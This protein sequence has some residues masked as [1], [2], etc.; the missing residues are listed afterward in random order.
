MRWP[1]LMLAMGLAWAP[2]QAQN[3]RIRK[4]PYEGRFLVR[5]G[6]VYVLLE[7]FAQALG[8]QLA[9][10]GEGY[11]SGPPDTGPVSPGPAAGILQVGSRQLSLLLESG[12]VFVPAEAYSQALGL[13]T[14]RDA[15]GALTIDSQ[16]EQARA[17][18]RRPP[19]DPESYF[20]TQYP[21]RYNRWASAR[22]A[23]CGPACMSMVA[24]AYGVA[25]QGLLPGDRQALILW[26][27]QSMTLG[28]QDQGRGTTYHEI[29]RAATQMGLSSRLIR[30]FQELDEALAQGQLVVVAGDTSR[31]GWGGGDHF[32]LCVGRRGSDY[33][34]ND[35]GGFCRVA[36]TRLPADQMEKFFSQAIALFPER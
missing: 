13:K 4:Q 20:V 9:P 30:R 17:A 16:S 8:V 25:P 24:L 10:A 18:V 1:L 7:P 34:I 12:D 6:Q 14:G 2:A 11:W 28:S 22:N 19:D 23:N 29:E 36:G 5:H 33:L 26:C 21:S 35:P 3:I 27:R 32:L 31:M 15:G